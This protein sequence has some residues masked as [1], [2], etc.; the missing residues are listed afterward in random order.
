[1]SLTLSIRNADR[2]E[3]GSPLSLV[4]DQRGAVIGRAAT[5][6]WSLPDPS[7][8]ISSRH[9]EVRFAE[10]RYELIDRS[11]NGT[12]LLGD[13]A[14]LPGPH[15]LG[16]GD[17]FLV[18]RF[19]I[20][21]ALDDAAAMRARSEPSAA[22]QWQGWDATNDAASAPAANLDSWDARPPG[23]AIS[24]TGP[25]S[26]SWAAPPTAAAS[27][28]SGERGA[29]S[30][31]ETSPWNVTPA[32]QVQPAS[33]WSSPVAR[34]SPPTADDIWGSFADSNV[35]D[36]ARGGF[37]QAANP[38]FP[39]T[40]P[41]L[42]SA[43]SPAF[44]APPIAA[45]GAAQ[46]PAAPPPATTPGLVAQTFAVALGVPAE[47]LQAGDE[48]TIALAG[49]LL[50]R[51][52]AGMVVMM[53]A[54][55]RAKSQLG[56]QGTSLEFDGNNPLKFAR[57]PELALE[58]VLNLPQRGFMDGERAVEDAFRDLQAHQMATLKAMQGALGSTL[59]RFSPVAIRARAGTGG[60]WSRILP[61]SRDAA[62][63]AAYEREFSGVVKGSDEAFMDIFATEFRRAYEEAMSQR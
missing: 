47:R 41:Q 34:P 9:C 32:A 24:G 43:Q 6:D 42:Q 58:Q 21:A 30:S 26:Q 48:Q 12:F 50:R 19:E 40:A 38:A 28:A 55:A 49:R 44:A 35:V 33:D 51:L 31:A 4:L 13:P 63:W 5:A 10:G 56:A 7:L 46:A 45:P 29:P 60:F 62:L 57:T 25:M 61:G 27:S 17:V 1:M 54:R 59:D 15:L 22:P 16:A 2:L 3:N 23:A 11:T 52:I 14:R 18:G 36:W 53:E 20:A 8:Y 39:P 37:G